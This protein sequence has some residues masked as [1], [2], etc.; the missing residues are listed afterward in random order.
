MGRVWLL[1]PALLG[2]FGLF[3]L[4]IFL[5]NVIFMKGHVSSKMMLELVSYER[6]HSVSFYK[7]K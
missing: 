7:N 2:G 1:L 5:I 6:G 3:A 4:K